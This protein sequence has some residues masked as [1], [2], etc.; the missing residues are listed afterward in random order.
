MAG[1]QDGGLAGDA[2]G[3]AFLGVQPF[4]DVHLF[5]IFAVA[6][7]QDRYIAVAD[8]DE[9]RPVVEVVGLPVLVADGSEDLDRDLLVGAL[10][11]ED[12]ALAGLRCDDLRAGTPDGSEDDAV[13]RRVLPEPVEVEKRQ[14]DV[15]DAEVRLR[16]FREAADVVGVRMGQDH[17]VETFRPDAFQFVL[18]DAVISLFPGVHE[19]REVRVLAVDERR[20]ALP[21]IEEAH[22][23]GLVVDLPFFDLLGHTEEFVDVLPGRKF[24][25]DLLA[26]GK[27][28]GKAKHYDCQKG[29]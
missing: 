6:G 19:H 20:G 23:E 16:Q 28:S 7:E 12:E 5:G 4:D 22:G 8:L 24:L 10:R 26:K 13:E 3:L 21:H 15:F 29:R 18:D 25:V 1:D 27:Q 2:G 14:H 17:I 11:V 9:D